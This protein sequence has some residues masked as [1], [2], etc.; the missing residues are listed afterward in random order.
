ME[1]P[2][3]LNPVIKLF[4]E[5]TKDGLEEKQLKSVKK[6][7]QCYQNELPLRDLVQ[8]FKILNVR[9]VK[10]ENQP[11][12]VESAYVSKIVWLAIF[13]KVSD[14]ITYAGHTANSVVLLGD[15]M[16]IPSSELRIQNCK[17]I[18]DFY[19][20]QPQKK[21]IPGYQQAS[22]SYKIQM[23]EFGGLAKTMVQ[24]MTLL[25]NQLVEKLWVLKI[26]QHLSTSEVNF[27]PFSRPVSF[28]Q[29]LN[30]GE[31]KCLRTRALD[32]SP[33]STPKLRDPEFEPRS[34]P[35][36]SL[37]PGSRSPAARPALTL[38]APGSSALCAKLKVE[39]A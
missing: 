14:E 16:K 30:L 24:L 10:I 2:V 28:S 18:V 6:L 8:T 25:E 37:Q 27:L 29:C 33:Y 20:A 23:A 38:S 15:L 3:D 35:F 39:A 22:S 36:R 11:H 17:R 34:S 5:T 32:L 26:L 1:V 4:E 19:Q 9:A 31:G 7:V 12:F 13:E 21:H